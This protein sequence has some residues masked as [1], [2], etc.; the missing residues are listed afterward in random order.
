M[1]L[2]SPTALPPS[3]MFPSLVATM[4]DVAHG[5][6]VSLGLTLSL[7]SPLHTDTSIPWFLITRVLECFFI[8]S[9]HAIDLFLWANTDLL[10]LHC[11]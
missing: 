8:L 7:P 3:D 10:R 9:F 11:V 4:L 1:P 6:Q 5:N 2:M